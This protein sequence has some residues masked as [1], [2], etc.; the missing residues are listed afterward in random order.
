TSA[1]NKAPGPDGL[2]FSSL[3]RAYTAIPQHFNALYAALGSTG[4]H[5]LIWRQAT[6]V[7]IPKPGKPDYST[8]KAYR[9]IALLNCLGKILEKLMA[10]RLAY[11]AERFALLHKDQIGGRPQRSAIDAALALSHR[12]DDAKNRKEHT[13]A[14]FM[15]VRGAFDNVSR[16]RL[17]STMKEMGL[18]P[19]VIKWTNH[20]LTDRLTALAFDGRQE[21]LSPVTTGIPQG[22][23]TS[24]ILFLIYLQPLFDKL[25]RRFPLIW[26][27]SYIDD[28]ALVVSGKDIA[29]NSRQLES[30]A[31]APLNGQTT[32]PSPST[33]AKPN[34]S[35]SPTNALSPSQMK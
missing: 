11:Y 10:Q 32:T 22:S 20:F 28:V 12:I 31:K 4:Y 9:P 21:A 15:D 8:P 27:P 2:P 16:S 35:T 33:T 26:A 18:P 34:S 3:R 7:I 13:S 24:P 6:T 30:A 19:P 29:R 5:P 17:V 25:T 14:L 1:A 23:P